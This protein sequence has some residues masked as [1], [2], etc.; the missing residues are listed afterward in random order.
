MRS[1]RFTTTTT[2]PRAMSPRAVTV[3]VCR[4]VRIFSPRTALPRPFKVEQQRWLTLTTITTEPRKRTTTPPHKAR[5]LLPRRLYS[6][7]E[8]RR[9]VVPRPLA[10]SRRPRPFP[11]SVSDSG[12]CMRDVLKTVAALAAFGLVVSWTAELRADEAVRIKSG[13][14]IVGSPVSLSGGAFQLVGNKGFTIAGGADGGTSEADCEPCLAGD[15]ISLTTQLRGSYFGAVTYKGESYDLDITNGNGNITFSSPDF[16]LP[17]SSGDNQFTIDQPFSLTASSLT[18][19]D[20]TVI[21]VEGGGTA[22]ARFSTFQDG[23]DTYYFLED[24]TFTFDD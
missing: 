16:V 14:V 21:P 10:L 11:L 9:A 4:R 5:R 3:T 7:K 8:R 6:V 24:I 22:S 18:L 1:A 2:G 12:G 15:T 23:G 20:G 17:P 19:P 13:T